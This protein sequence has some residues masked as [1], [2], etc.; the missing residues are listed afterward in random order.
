[1]TWTAPT[2][3]SFT[4]AAQPF[5]LTSGS[6]LYLVVDTQDVLIEPTTAPVYGGNW[7]TVTFWARFFANVAA[8][9]AQEVAN[10][11]NHACLLYAAAGSPPAA[12]A[13][14]NTSNE[15]VVTAALTLASN[16]EAGPLLQIAPQSTALAA[17][18]LSA[19]IFKPNPWPGFDA[20]INL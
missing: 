3:A 12:I 19:G 17:L 7:V 1:M 14:V 13:T 10:V 6:V 15:V 11:I 8:A 20:P 18:G 9:T 2:P 16:R 4:T 5:A